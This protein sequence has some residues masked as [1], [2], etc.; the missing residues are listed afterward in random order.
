MEKRYKIMVSVIALAFSIGAACLGCIGGRQFSE[1]YNAF[2]I[3]FLF[4]YAVFGNLMVSYYEFSQTW[5]REVN[6]N[7]RLI[8]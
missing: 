5:E 6:I 3:Q 8:E 7:L 1:F 2:C 4:C